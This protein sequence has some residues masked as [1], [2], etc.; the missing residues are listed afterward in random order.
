MR[1]GVT[2]EE[3]SALTG[4]LRDGARRASEHHAPLDAQARAVGEW[5]AGRAAEVAHAF[6][7]TL[8]QAAREAANGLDDLTDRVETAAGTYTEVEARASPVR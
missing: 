6:F 1:Y 5:C 8:A 3:V 4:R 2:T 7:A